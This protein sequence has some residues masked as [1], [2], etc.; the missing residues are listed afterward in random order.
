MEVMPVAKTDAVQMG[1]KCLVV[2]GCCT[3]SAL[4]DCAIDI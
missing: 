1:K 3:L 4:F 2:V